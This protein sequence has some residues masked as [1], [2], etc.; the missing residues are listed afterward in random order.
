MAPDAYAPCKF[1]WLRWTHIVLDRTGKA[2]Y[3]QKIMDR[4]TLLT[5]KV[6]RYTSYPTAPHFH[7][8]VN[9]ETYRR[10]LAEL[11]QNTGVSLYLHIP[12]C[13]TLCW[14]CGCH[15]TAV[16]HYAPVKAYLETLMREV[17][18]AA[19]IL[20]PNHP[21]TH[22]HIG[23]G[24]PTI[25]SADDFD[26]LADCMHRHFSIAPATEFAIEIDP[27]GLTDATIAAM[28]KIGVT[29]ASIG[30]QDENPAVQKA[31][32]RLQP[33]DV[34]K[35]AVDRLRAVGIG[36]LNIDL[37]YGLP[38]QSESDL[39]QTI[40]KTL[41]LKPD[42]FAV[43]GYAHV[44]HF[45]KLMNL[46]ETA[47]LPP[48]DERL[49]QFD[50]AHSRLCAAGYVPIGLDHF[51]LPNDGLAQ[52][53]A[54][55]TLVRNFQGY[56]DDTAAAL[57]GFGASAIGGMPQGYIQNA[58]D[59]PSYRK[60]VEAGNFAVARGVAISP[61]DRLRRAVIEKLMCGLSVDLSAVATDFG[62]T[63]AHF[64]ADV[65]RLQPLAEAGYVRI[66]G[67]V[68]TVPTAHRFGVRLVAA[69]FDA[70]LSQGGAVHSAAV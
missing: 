46:I 38:H 41:T 48:P 62:T 69:A 34:T 53:L 30:V 9:G 8:G 5:A 64:S 10:W 20:G 52:A 45:K 14:F 29:R 21:V 47:A 39:N 15:T 56:T 54:A 51:S 37:M 65:D 43:F 1:G 58:A 3:Q 24:S 32:N 13:D 60:A 12:F 31:I 57:I 61:E 27:R 16:N 4:S 50:L 35:S 63:A 23:G 18:M 19:A 36:A 49:A 11:P 44:P 25:L 68:I 42:R 66:D 26:R 7:A 67:P 17:E 33:H 40:E 59:V 28:A 55:G 22:M 2:R 70:Y 6:P